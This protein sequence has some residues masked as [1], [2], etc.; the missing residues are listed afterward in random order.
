MTSPLS[1]KM[2]VALAGAGAG[3]TLL[4]F[5][6]LRLSELLPGHSLPYGTLLVNLSGAF[7]AGLLL[8]LARHK[9]PGWGPYLPVVMIGFFGAFTTF[10]SFAL[11]TAGMLYDGHLLKA[12][13]Y[14]AL[15]NL[16]GLAAVG[17]GSGCA[18]FWN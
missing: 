8:S 3:G 17:A 12:I 2:L 5:F 18:S 7:L 13:A 9:F 14:L 15:Q 11:E 6:C 1:L 10:S 16:G 4:R